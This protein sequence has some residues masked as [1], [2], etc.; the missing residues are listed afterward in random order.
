[1][2]PDGGRDGFQFSPFFTTKAFSKK[3]RKKQGD[4]MFCEQIVPN[5]SLV[6]CL[7]LIY[8]DTHLFVCRKEALE[9]WP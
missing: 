3:E 2:T 9:S 8:V 1:L 7:K 4:Q 6:F 5:V